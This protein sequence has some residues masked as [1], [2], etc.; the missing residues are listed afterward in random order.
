MIWTGRPSSA[1]AV[2]ACGAK[3]DAA[4]AMAP[5]IV[6]ASL[7]AVAV[8]LVASTP[9]VV[10]ASAQSAVVVV[11]VPSLKFSLK[12]SNVFDVATRVRNMSKLKA[13]TNGVDS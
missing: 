12:T 9:L 11:P 10:V 6:A 5:A 4:V 7:A 2:A 1:E 8:D 13:K 3:A